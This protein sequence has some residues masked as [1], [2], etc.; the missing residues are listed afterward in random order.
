MVEC[1]KEMLSL[2][3]QRPTYIIMDALGDLESS[4]TSR[5]PSPREE[6]LELV[7]ELVC[8]H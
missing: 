2:E 3:V 6:V 1:L 7:E 5:I 4:I 8:L